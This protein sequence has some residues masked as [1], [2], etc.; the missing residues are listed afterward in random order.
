MPDGPPPRF[1]EWTRGRFA[2]QP[3]LAAAAVVLGWLVTDPFGVRLRFFSEGDQS[4]EMG[5][6]FLAAACAIACFRWHRPLWQAVHIAVAVL[7]CVP[8]SVFII[9]FVVLA[10]MTFAFLGS[11]GL[12]FE[13]DLGYVI[14]ETRGLLGLLLAFSPVTAAGWLLTAR[15]VIVPY[16]H[17]DPLRRAAARRYATA[18]V[19]TLTVGWFGLH[20]LYLRRPRRALL[21]ATTLGLLGVG[22][23]ADLVAWSRGRM[24]D[25]AGRPIRLLRAPPP[26]P[27]AVTPRETHPALAACTVIA[28]F[29]VIAILGLL[30]RGVRLL[31]AIPGGLA[32]GFLGFVALTILVLLVHNDARETRQTVATSLAA[33]VRLQMRR[34]LRL[35]LRAARRA[36]GRPGRVIRQ[37]SMLIWTDADADLEAAILDVHAGAAEAWTRRT[38]GP[39]NLPARLRLFYFGDEAAMR[40]YTGRLLSEQEAAMGYF[41]RHGVPH[42]VV[43]GTW[44]E[45]PPSTREHVLAHEFAHALWHGSRLRTPKPWIEEGLAQRLAAEIAPLPDWNHRFACR[46]RRDRERGRLVPGRH[47]LAM[48]RHPPAA[49]PNAVLEERVVAAFRHQADLYRQ[50]ALLVGWLLEHHGDAFRALLRDRAGL[51]DATAEGFARRFGIGPDEAMAR[52]VE[53]V[54]IPTTT[55]PAPPSEARSILDA[56]LF[57]ILED[58][59]APVRLKLTA[60]SRLA[61][62]AE[63]EHV[64]RLEACRA[65]LHPALHGELDEA[66][67]LI[68]STVEAAS[69]E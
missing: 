8:A 23:V 5:L 3:V 53:A 4:Y 27:A 69:A 17:P 46:L 62:L 6:G 37:E 63:S 36:A 45:L 7:L 54:L 44:T 68:A 42:V 35:D 43:A 49:P 14:R 12:L 34:I 65:K 30:D 48:S 13:R 39:A 52:A 25:G 41:V 19:L 15:Q 1:R 20:H 56:R 10:G 51:R 2:F 57:P 59:A 29:S 31:Y 16:T 40:A 64:P 9:A 55:E 66:I 61:L 22:V 50:S 58:P 47:L 18:L 24:V 33:L 32:L 38:G 26:V 60:L 21:Y 11:I 67:Q 28:I